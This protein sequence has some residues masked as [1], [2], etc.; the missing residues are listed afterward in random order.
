MSPLTLEEENKVL[1]KLKEND[2]A[3]REELILHNM[4]L[5]AHVIK[6]YAVTEEDKEELLS[7]GT[8]GPVSY[9]H[10]TLPTKA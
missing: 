10:L 4:R 3:A 2:E 5:V 1:A 9:T 8:I 6:K 7:I